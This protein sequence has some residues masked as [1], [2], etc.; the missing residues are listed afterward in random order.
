MPFTVGTK[1]REDEHEKPVTHRADKRRR[2]SELRQRFK[3]LYEDVTQILFEEDPIRIN[4]ETNI[5]EYEPEVGTI[6]P[7]LR[8]CATAEEVRTV[9]HTEFVRLFGPEIAG[10]AEK[11]TSAAKRIWDAFQKQRGN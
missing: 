10:P 11:Y 1:T 6:L 5:D 4:F 2:R 7:R 3:R 8:K 9:V